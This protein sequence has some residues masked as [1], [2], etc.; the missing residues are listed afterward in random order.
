MPS[1]S[2]E[3]I[4]N[5]RNP[6]KFQGRKTYNNFEFRY[7]ARVMVSM[8]NNSKPFLDFQSRDQQDRETQEA[9]MSLFLCVCLSVTEDN[10]I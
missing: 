3:G 7:S 6:K 8:M 4:L 5:K 10:Y 9:T 2:N 1:T